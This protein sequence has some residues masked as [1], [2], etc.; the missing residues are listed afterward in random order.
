MSVANEKKEIRISA[1]QEK[2]LAREIADK[3]NLEY[4]ELDDFE[5]DPELFRSMPADLMLKYS[6]I[7]LKFKDGVLRIAISDASNVLI[8][9]ELELLLGST[10]EIVISTL[11]A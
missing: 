7:P 4:L 9:D 5:I 3:Y 6:F 11:S 10:I 8:R 1:E 2:K